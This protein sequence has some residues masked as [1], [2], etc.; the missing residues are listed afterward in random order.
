MPGQKLTLRTDVV[1]RLKEYSGQPTRDFCQL[2]AT[3]AMLWDAIEEIQ[4]LRE[5]VRYAEHKLANI[6]RTG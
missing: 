1:E 4:E 5:R 6:I 2:G 3:G